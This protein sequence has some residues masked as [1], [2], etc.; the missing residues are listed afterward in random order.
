MKIIL[1]KHESE[2]VFRVA[3]SYG[4]N[5]IN[6]AFGLEL[7]YLPKD[8]KDAKRDAIVP[9]MQELNHADVLLWI[10]KNGNQL[11]LIDKNNDSKIYFIKLSHVHK[12]VKKS[13]IIHL[14][15]GIKE[16][17]DNVNSSSILQTVFFNQ[18]LYGKVI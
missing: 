14:A 4:L 9:F 11:A 1:E 18:V 10:L 12:R 17:W 2:E 6:N 15:E 16:R 8:Y 5:Y 3:L 7:L 13:Q